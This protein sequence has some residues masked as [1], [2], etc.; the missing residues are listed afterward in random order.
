LSEFAPIQV[1]GRNQWTGFNDSPATY[2][3][4]GHGAIKDKNMGV[5]GMVFLDDLGG[6]I[7]QT[8]LIANYSYQL[9]L[10]TDSKLSF[11][12]SGIL[13][14]YTYDGSDIQAASQNDPSLYSNTKALVPDFNFGLAYTLKK[15][16]KIGISANQL[17]Q[18]RLT[19]WNEMNLSIDAEN[20][21]IRHYFLSGSY[22]AE[23][24]ES[25][26]VEPYTVLRTTFITPIQFE[27]GA[28]LVYKKDF[29][30][31]IGYRY[32]DA[33]TIMIGT[34]FNNFLFGYS[35]DITTSDLRGFSS[36]SHEIL[37]GYRLQSKNGK[38]A[39]VK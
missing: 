30:A 7:T 29:Y 18:S 25:I 23:V 4:G 12:V 5:G 13:N 15:R 17:L 26:E 16:L 1:G 32:Q 8:G 9:V 19:K 31:G 34:T 21:L 11:G 14:Q 24:T 39:R 27:L 3:L 36:G 33:L 20:R 2:T 38:T 28:R 37:L 35:Y 10:N 22:L 6:A